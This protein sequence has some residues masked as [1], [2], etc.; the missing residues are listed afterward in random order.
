MDMPIKVYFENF[1]VLLKDEYFSTTH[2]F[3]DIKGK[4]QA[5]VLQQW[6]QM[7]QQD[8]KMLMAVTEW[9]QNGHLKRRASTND[10][11]NN[12]QAGLMQL[13]TPYFIFKC[14]PE[15]KRCHCYL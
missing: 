2:L 6:N 8:R 15:R 14:A 1:P 5:L 11:S 13:I 9:D 12:D 7:P 10:Y 3:N 4:L